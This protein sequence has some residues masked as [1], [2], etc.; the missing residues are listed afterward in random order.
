M[1][2]PAR[3]YVF[4]TNDVP[5]KDRLSRFTANSAH[6]GTIPGSEVIL[7]QDPQEAHTEHHGG[8]VNFGND[9]SSTSRPASTS[10]PRTHRT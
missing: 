2:P 10:A 6:T 7:Y 4:Y 1:V 8:A 9:A 5:N 3:Y